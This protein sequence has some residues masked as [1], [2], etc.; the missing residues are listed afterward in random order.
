[1]SSRQ[2]IDLN[3]WY[4]FKKSS[5]HPYTPSLRNDI[6]HTRHPDHAPESIVR[7]EQF[8]PPSFDRTNTS[9]ALGAYP[10]EQRT[11]DGLE[12]MTWP[13]EFNLSRPMNPIPGHPAPQIRLPKHG[14]TQGTKTNTRRRQKKQVKEAVLTYH[15]LL[16][17]KA[18]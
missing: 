3:D 5:M 12:N 9:S 16:I 13:W 8:S 6:D 15:N 2:D 10:H 4:L 17:T 18:E 14:S 1:M 11:P 7:S